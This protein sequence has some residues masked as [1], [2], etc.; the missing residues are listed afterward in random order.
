MRKILLGTFLAAI[1]LIVAGS[2]RGTWADIDAVS[3]SERDAIF[4]AGWV[5]LL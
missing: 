3:A 5:M 4:E 1:V 2:G